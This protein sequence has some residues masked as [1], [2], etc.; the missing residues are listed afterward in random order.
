MKVA[1]IGCL[2]GDLDTAAA[3]LRHESA[4]HGNTVDLALVCGDLQTLRDHADLASCAIPPRFHNAA[5]RNRMDGYLDGS[6]TLP[7]LMICVG[8]NHEA[9]RCLL[10]L[11][12]GGWICPGMYYLGTSGIVKVGGVTIAGISGIFKEY[13][14][15]KGRVENKDNVVQDRRMKASAYHLRIWDVEKAKLDG[16]NRETEVDVVLSHEW[17]AKVARYGD[18]KELIRK[19]PYFA[20]EISRGMLGSPPLD[21]IMDAFK[22]AYWFAAHLHVKYPALIYHESNMCE[23]QQKVTQFLALDKILPRRHWLQILDITSPEEAQNAL[24]DEL[25]PPGVD[26][27]DEM[28]IY[29]E[30]KE[31]RLE[32]DRHWLATSIVMHEYFTTEYQQIHIPDKSL[33]CE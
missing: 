8:G 30:E 33:L 13:D 23:E 11:Q 3:V 2:H 29:S 26:S 12:M 31:L 22:P 15:R 27:D 20:D 21:E 32:Y 6:K 10:D 19:K 9:Q 5:I 24:Q 17:P 25:R 7:C 14:Y 1:V 4:V 18:V 16:D 28:K